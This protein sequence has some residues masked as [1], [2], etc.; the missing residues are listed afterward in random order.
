MRGALASL[1]MGV[2][3]G[4]E[5]SMPGGM[6]SAGMPGAMPSMG[7]QSSPMSSMMMGI[8]MGLMHPGML[9]TLG[10]MQSGMSK[11][12]GLGQQLGGQ[13]GK[14]MGQMASGAQA[15]GVPGS[16]LMKL[17]TN[18]MQ[19]L[20]TQGMPKPSMASQPQS[21]QPMRPMQ[22]ASQRSP[23]INPE[24]GRMDSIL[25]TP[26]N[27][28]ALSGKIE[29]ADAHL[30][31]SV[32]HPSQAD[33]TFRP[34]P[35]AGQSRG[36]DMDRAKASIAGIESRGNQNPYGA[37]NPKTGAVGKYQVMPSN[38]GPWTKQY[39]GQALT[40][41]QF[42]N[43]P[44]AQEKVFEGQ[45]GA[46]AKKYGPEG[47]ARAWFAGEKGMNNP[48]ATDANRTSVSGYASRFAQNYGA[49][50]TSSRS[51]APPS[52]VSQNQAATP[53]S[54]TSQPAMGANELQVRQQIAQQNAGQQRQSPLS[55]ISQQLMK[56]KPPPIPHIEM[57]Q[58]SRP[59]P[60]YLAK[61]QQGAQQQDQQQPQSWDDVAKNPKASLTD[62]I[63][64]A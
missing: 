14:P 7:M 42:R 26:R 48:R 41:Q 35:V 19:G 57:A 18:A 6:M 30:P 37:V 12:G 38:V 59:V 23:G 39:Y 31:L 50:A 28:A 3:M 16:G 51:A 34:Q 21:M 44:Q 49:P 10:G 22:Q 58:V 32:A 63:G 60:N 25:D 24:T 13:L 43:N 53:Q 15:L 54:S 36:F 45:F 61:G 1:L 9:Q 46:Y 52:Q 55:Q 62:L 5:G 29:G 56:S 2:F 47:A 40:P 8:G 64:A 20:P 27:T 17:G 4:G 11:L 33:T